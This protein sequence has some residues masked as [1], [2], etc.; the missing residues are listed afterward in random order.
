MY[1]EISLIVA[2]I[3]LIFLSHFRH[4]G[5]GHRYVITA[6]FQTPSGSSFTR[7][8]FHTVHFERTDRI[9]TETTDIY[10]QVLPQYWAP[11]RSS[12]CMIPFFAEV[13]V[14]RI[15]KW[16]EL[17]KNI[18]RDNLTCGSSTITSRG[19]RP[20]LLTW[21]PRIRNLTQQLSDKRINKLHITSRP[22]T[23]I[24]FFFLSHTHTHTHTH[25][26]F[27]FHEEKRGPVSQT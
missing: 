16:L 13:A 8:T 12:P 1:V 27:M 3:A 19:E 5:L 7:F 4:H 9:T 18:Y 11:S 17:N 21:P 14:Q 26:F 25:T 23:P 15:N 20:R 22:Q 10:P 24:I 6:S 2:E